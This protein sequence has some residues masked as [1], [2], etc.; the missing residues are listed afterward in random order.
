MTFIRGKALFISLISIGCIAAVLGIL[1]MWTGMLGAIL[2]GQIMGTLLVTGALAS[3]LMAVDYDMP[4]S[5]AKLMLGILMALAFMA[6]GLIL[7]QVW[8]S[9]LAFDVFCKLLVTLVILTAL[10]AFI[11]A[12]HEDFGSNKKLKDDNY[13]D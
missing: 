8:F 12:A 2:F 1:Q 9:W 4:G 7:Q 5:K 11:L 3:F 13:I 6:T 10:V